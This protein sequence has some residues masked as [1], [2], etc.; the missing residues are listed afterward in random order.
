MVTVVDGCN[1]DVVLKGKDGSV[2]YTA[3][4]ARARQGQ[5]VVQRKGKAKDTARL[6]GSVT[7]QARDQPHRLSPRRAEEFWGQ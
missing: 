7:T 3:V 4:S 2:T 1:T 5:A 6:A